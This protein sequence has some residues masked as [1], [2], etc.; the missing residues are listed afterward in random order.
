VNSHVRPRSGLYDNATMLL[1]NAS[2]QIVTHERTTQ[3]P[4][5]IALISFPFLPLPLHL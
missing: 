2:W 4:S 3:R 5:T 1:F